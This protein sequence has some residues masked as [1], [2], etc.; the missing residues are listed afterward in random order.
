M[1]LAVQNQVRTV[2]VAIGSNQGE[3]ERYIRAAL[4]ELFLLKNISDLSCSSIYETPP[5][6][7]E[8]DS[9]FNVVC[10]FESDVPADFLLHRLLE[11]E[12]RW[13]RVRVQNLLNQPRTLDLD[14]LWIAGESMT[15]DFL[16]IPHPRMRGRSFVRYP[17]QELGFNSLVFGESS[18]DDL[19]LSE[20][21][22]IKKRSDL[23]GFIEEWRCE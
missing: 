5:Y 4:L 15:S 18:A 11:I 7:A 22:D 19:V 21:Q 23:N 8:G 14:L 6:L 10:T 20:P 17:I 3:R 16:T 13:G 1:T 2:L 12:S 9:Y